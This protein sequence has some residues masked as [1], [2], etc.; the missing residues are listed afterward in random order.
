MVTALGI[1]IWKD[2]GHEE[3]RKQLIKADTDIHSEEDALK[4]VNKIANENM[5]YSKP[6][7][8]F[9]LQEDYSETESL[10]FLRIHHAFADA[11]GFVGMMSMIND[12]KYKL[13]SDKKMPEAN[14]FL[15]IFFAIVGPFYVNYIF[16]KWKHFRN[17][18]ENARKID[19]TNGPVTYDNKFYS[20][21]NRIPFDKIRPCYKR[22]KDKTTFNDYMMGIISV[23]FDKWY[24]AHGIEGARN[25]KS[26]LSINLRPL[27]KKMDD[28]KLDNDV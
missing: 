15:H 24:K 2:L 18:D 3:A 8:E 27:P 1:S 21:K 12:D 16:L 20:A 23:C 7:W 6:L 28:V 5:D 11:G 25:I 14:I 19:E 9:Y 4:H 10:F 17:S 13:T 22:F 26:L